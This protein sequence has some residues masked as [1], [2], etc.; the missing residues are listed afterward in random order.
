MKA[1]VDSFIS[2]YNNVAKAKL[3]FFVEEKM[4]MGNPYEN[5]R[6]ITLKKGGE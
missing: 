5:S 3:G 6:N 1:F 4:E 2:Y